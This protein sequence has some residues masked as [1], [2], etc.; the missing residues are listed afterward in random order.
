MYKTSFRLR[1]CALLLLFCASAAQAR[2]DYCVGNEAQLQAAI[3]AADNDG[4]AS[5]ISLRP[6]A[7]TLTSDL[8]Y[9]Q[10]SSA[11]EGALTLRGGAV[12]T[13]CLASI[14]G[15]DG[16]TIAGL[17]ASTFLQ[18]RGE[19]LIQDLTFVGVDVSITKLAPTTDAVHVQRV[20]ML[21]AGMV[22]NAPSSEVLV[23]DSVFKNGAD[24]LS[25]ADFGL[26]INASQNNASDPENNINL[27]NVSVLD[28]FAR[29]TGAN[30][31]Q[32][33]RITNSIF[34][35]T[36]TELESSASLIVRNSRS[37]GIQMLGG[38]T[39]TSSGL[40]AFGTLL[41]AQY[42]PLSGSPMLDR[43][44]SGVYG[45]L[46]EFDL[47]GEARVVG[48]GVDIGGAESPVDGN[49]VVI[50]DTT[51]S[52]GAG[53]L[54]AAITF[55][56]TD[57]APNIIRFNIPG[58][59]CP[60]RIVRTAALTITDGVVIDGY[61][62]PGS[63]PPSGTRNF[64]G[65]PCILLDGTD[66]THV[67]IATGAALDTN[68]ESVSIKGLAFEDFSNAV[69]LTNGSSHVLQ[70]N[71]FGGTIGNSSAALASND[72]AIFLGTDSA[73]IGGLSPA[74]A[75]LIGGGNISGISIGIGAD[76]NF[77]IGNQIGYDPSSSSDALASNETGINVN[78]A[79]NQIL[80]N[81]IAGNRSNG[82][83]LLNA[84]AIG[85]QIGDN[86]IGLQAS[87]G[88]PANGSNGLIVSGES[89]NNQIGPNNRIDGNLGSGV[90]ISASA[91]GGNRIERNSISGNTQLGVDLDADGVTPNNNDSSICNVS[92]GC[93]SNNNQN[94][95][96]LTSAL[97][98]PATLLIPA[99]LTVAGSLRSLVRADPYRIEF[100][101]SASCDAS[102][103][104]EGAV[105]IEA[106][107]LTI[108]NSGVCSGTVGVNCRRAFNVP[109]DPTGVQAG[110]SITAIA[111]ASNGD[112]SEF[113]AC[114]TVSASGGDS[115]FADGFE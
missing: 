95:P 15:A 69:Q 88:M 31:T 61:S 82:I 4:D 68:D 10:S 73:L 17:F 3:S 52:S 49:G 92:T 24:V 40:T 80:G 51:A 110:D 104:G 58:S 101:Q 93:T 87:L 59:T 62:Q 109:I 94:F 27:V 102:G 8:N 20:L 98:R 114:V 54:A 63:V 25:V 47:Y 55:A 85:N 2:I 50:V 26:L 78:G 18:R 12:G 7:Y 71:Q 34:Q 103:F 9:S 45:G 91:G 81:R 77:I 28:A 35:R 105:F 41:N 115:I 19:I 112:S 23:R 75:N 22:V 13:T 33:V 64:T 108:A 74:Q 53:S 30:R 96:E 14:A 44:L 89:N 36:G 42:Q 5:L 113:S 76:S 65:E 56:N 99:S 11:S 86:T 97:L 84:G 39:L 107:D 90:R 79:D 1:I 43:G 29:I 57:S 60:K 70:G 21:S 106:I 37:N 38:A 66:R 6:G 83:F 48:A 32:A 16:T 72:R 46:P 100:Y 67:G 111:T